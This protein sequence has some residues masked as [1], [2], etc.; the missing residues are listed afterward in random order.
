MKYFSTYCSWSTELICASAAVLV[1]SPEAVPGMNWIRPVAPLPALFFCPGEKLPPVSKLIT[2]I[3]Y[4]G[5]VPSRAAIASTPWM[6]CGV[7]FGLPRTP[8]MR[9]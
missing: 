6:N 9:L 2:A 4:S 3:R 7:T 1:P 5:L 8:A